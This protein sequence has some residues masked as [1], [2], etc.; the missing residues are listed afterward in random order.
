M[1]HSQK[2]KKKTNVQKYCFASPSQ[3][4]SNSIPVLIQ[5]ERCEK[6]IGEIQ[7]FDKQEQLVSIKHY[8]CGHVDTL[9]SY[10]TGRGITQKR[11][12][13]GRTVERLFKFFVR[14]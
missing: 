1:L 13:M 8:F 3:V 4:L 6:R 2:S 5:T 11:G 9:G 10:T 7:C 12:G 14:L